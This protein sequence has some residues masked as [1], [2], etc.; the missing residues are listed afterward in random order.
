[1]NYWFLFP[2]QKMRKFHLI[3]WRGAPA[4]TVFPQNFQPRKS[5]KT[6]V[7]YVFCFFILNFKQIKIN[8]NLQ[9]TCFWQT[10]CYWKHDLNWTYMWRLYN[11]L[12]VPWTSYIRLGKSNITFTSLLISSKGYYFNNRWKNC[13]FL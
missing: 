10:Q 2:L 8:L 9:W 5:G 6:T 12:D 13:L 4:E 3:S 11:V 1:M 7:L